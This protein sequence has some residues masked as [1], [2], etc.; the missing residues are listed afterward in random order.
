MATTTDKTSAKVVITLGDKY[1]SG[2]LFYKSFY[3]YILTLIQMVRFS[4]R[5]IA[6]IFLYGKMSLILLY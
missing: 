3:E 6:Y 4:N 2:F 1:H 5:D